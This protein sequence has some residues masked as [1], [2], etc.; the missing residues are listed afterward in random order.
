MLAVL[1]ETVLNV[2]RESF[3][4]FSDIGEKKACS[5]LLCK[6]WHSCLKKLFQASLANLVL[7]EVTFGI[8]LQYKQKKSISKQPVGPA[9]IT[10]KVETM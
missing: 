9:K 10:Q 1:C 8:K 6:P 7:L 4:C 3:I 5:M 2:A